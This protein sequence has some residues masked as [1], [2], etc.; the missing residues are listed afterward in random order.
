[1]PDGG[2]DE[3]AS[4]TIEVHRVILSAGMEV[5]AYVQ[6]NVVRDF[7]LSSNPSYPVIAS[8]QDFPVYVNRADDYCPGNA[9]YDYAKNEGSWNNIYNTTN[10]TYS[11]DGDIRTM[12]RGA[13]VTYN[14]DLSDHKLAGITGT[15]YGW[16]A[17]EKAGTNYEYDGN[18]NMVVDR[19]KKMRVGYDWRNLPIKF[20]FYANVDDGSNPIRQVHMIYDAS[21]KRLA[22]IN[23]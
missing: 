16:E 5:N 20:T 11:K 19:S 13:P 1:V 7:V 17:D 6:A 14:Y 22:K 21:G 9:W 4:E 10:L 15:A 3:Y 8:Q 12:N 23:E 18:G 2:N